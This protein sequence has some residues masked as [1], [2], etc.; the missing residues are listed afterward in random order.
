MLNIKSLH[1][2]LMVEQIKITYFKYLEV[3]LEKKF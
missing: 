1:L 3:M 2:K